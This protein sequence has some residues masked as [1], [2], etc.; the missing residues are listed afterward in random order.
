[1]KSH[2]LKYKCVKDEQP[3]I[4]EATKLSDITE[5]GEGGQKN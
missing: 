1:M 3:D 4:Q 2:N 5:G